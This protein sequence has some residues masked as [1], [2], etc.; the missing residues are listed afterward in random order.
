MGLFRTTAAYD[1]ALANWRGIADRPAA[2]N[3]ARRTAA[4]A[5]TPRSL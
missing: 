1:E 3:L 4:P 5:A 2:G